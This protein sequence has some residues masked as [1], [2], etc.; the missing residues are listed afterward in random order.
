MILERGDYDQ[1]VL[2][3]RRRY[4]SSATASS[5]GGAI[6]NKYIDEDGAEVLIA[7][8]DDLASC[9]EDMMRDRGR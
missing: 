8:D 6:C 1:F 5:S 4:F 7:H 2:D 3:V 9:F